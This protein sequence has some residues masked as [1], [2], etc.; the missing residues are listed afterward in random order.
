MN[1]SAEELK[2]HVCYLTDNIGVRLA[3]SAAEHQAA[4]YIAD[5]FRKYSDN[6]KIFDYPVI[7]RCVVSEKL[8]VE[9]NGK[10]QEFPCSLFGSAPTTG[11]KCIDAEMVFFD[12]ATGYQREDLSFLSGK[13]VVHLGCHIE[14]EDAYRR[15]MESKPAF[16]LFVDTRYT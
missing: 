6:V 3:G 16:I 4:E 14:S 13:A 1:F 15:L 5:E 2:R 8:E 10:W 7:E 11:G 9:I 12:T